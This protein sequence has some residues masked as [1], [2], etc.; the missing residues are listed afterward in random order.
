M[1]AQVSK[2]QAVEVHQAGREAKPLPSRVGVSARRSVPGRFAS[3]WWIE[4]RFQPGEVLVA[5]MTDPDWEPTMKMAS[6][7]VTNR[8]GRTCHAAIVSRELGVPCA[9]GTG[10]ATTLKPGQVV[11]VCCAQG[12]TA[13]IYD[14][15]IPFTCDRI[16]TGDSAGADEDDGQRGESRPGLR[17]G[18]PAE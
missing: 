16:D 9:V 10:R 14:G 3:T 7:I 18:G 4:R 17:P 1:H 11:T 12:E 6:A 5:D 15:R 8:G 13:Q 2:T